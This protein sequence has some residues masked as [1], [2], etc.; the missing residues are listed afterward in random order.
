MV[1]PTIKRLPT[2]PETQVHPWVAKF[3]WRRKWQPTPVLL[4]GESHGW[5][6]LVGYNPWGHKELDT[7][8][9]QL[10]LSK[11]IRFRTAMCSWLINFFIIGEWLSL[12][13]F[14]ALKS[15]LPNFRRYTPGLWLLSKCSICFHSW[16]EFFVGSS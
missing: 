15:T 12:A 14:F 3:P 13:V 10:S 9:W 1:A 7:T 16:N 6:S 8:D 5:R 2:R 4:P 11:Y